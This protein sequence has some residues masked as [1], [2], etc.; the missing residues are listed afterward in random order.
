MIQFRRTYP[1][2]EDF[3]KLGGCAVTDVVSLAGE[4][5]MAVDAV[6]NH[7]NSE[8]KH[9]AQRKN[10]QRLQQFH[11]DRVLLIIVNH[12]RECSAWLFHAAGA[13]TTAAQN[14][15]LPVL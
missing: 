4:V 11:D 8:P 3:F 14:A 10:D 9:G 7:G 12:T 5:N 15:L 6:A 1:G 2:A 13:K